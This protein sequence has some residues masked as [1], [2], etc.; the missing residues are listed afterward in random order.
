MN[1]GLI[2]SDLL[3][4]ADHNIAYHNY[5][6]NLVSFDFTVFMYNNKNELLTVKYAQD[7]PASSE[8]KMECYWLNTS[9][10]RRKI[11]TIKPFSSIFTDILSSGV[12]G[13]I[14]RVNGLNVHINNQKILAETRKYN[15]ID[16]MAIQI[17]GARFW[18]SI[19]DDEGEYSDEIE[20][21]I[22]IQ[23][24]INF[25]KANYQEFN[26]LD[27]H[28]IGNTF[29]SWDILPIETYVFTV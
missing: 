26:N 3:C 1:L 27:N 14:D 19:K 22:T 16:H 17:V 12:W 6:I 10:F 28:P 4:T 13:E 29:D 21:T 9:G 24:A 11:N 2:T 15:F 8:D 23:D 18:Q 5:E 25:I 20:E 7:C